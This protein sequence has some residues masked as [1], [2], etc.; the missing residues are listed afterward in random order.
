MAGHEA[1]TGVPLPAG[2]PCFFLDFDGT[3]VDHAPTPGS[4]HVPPGLATLLADLQ[5]A[6]DGA[7]AIVTGR[8]LEDIDRHLAPLRLPTAAVHGAVRRTAAG[9]VHQAADPAGIIAA[10]DALRMPLQ[11]HVASIP[12]LLL[13][14]KGLALAVHFRGAPQAEDATRA[15]LSGLLAGG[16]HGLDLLE[17]ACVLEVRPAHTGKGQAVEAFLRERPFAGRRPVFIGDDL[18]DLGGM[19]AAQRHGGL[20]IGVGDRVQGRWQLESPA[21]VHDWLRGC[22]ARG[23]RP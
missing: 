5:R 15:L 10:I 9:I 2:R 11:E 17:G 6:N 21:A 12:G 16:T 13:E 7:L 4:I 19:H 1:A 8:A 20:A 23:D 18:T 14:D 3:L 22:L